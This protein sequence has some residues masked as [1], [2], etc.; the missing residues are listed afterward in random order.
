MEPD[1]PLPW[2]HRLIL[3][4]DLIAQS[5]K[6]PSTKVGAVLVGPDMEVR[7]TGFNG[8]PIGVN[9]R[10]P[11]RW[12]RP[13]KYSFV[14]HAERN[15]IDLAARTGTRTEGTTLYLNWEPR[16]CDDC[17]KTLIQAGIVEIVGPNRPFT[18][19]RDWGMSASN[20][21]LQEAGVRTRTVEIEQGELYAD[22]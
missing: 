9:E 8:F 7:S 15:A 6:D 16:P 21:M 20:K 13:D 19:N 5:S 18:N 1:E 10:E 22:G 11:G 3:Q 14:A 2:D 17:T 12:E 4:A